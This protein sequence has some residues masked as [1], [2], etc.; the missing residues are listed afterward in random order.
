MIIF[1]LQM[2]YFSYKI[3]CNYNIYCTEVG[4]KTFPITI[5]IVRMHYKLPPK[6]TQHYTQT[7]TTSISSSF[8]SLTELKPLLQLKQD[9]SVFTLTHLPLSP[10][11]VKLDSD[12]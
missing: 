2:S 3:I 12:K 8:H 9:N 10:G 1:F 7:L 6:I 4:G 11:Q 5:H